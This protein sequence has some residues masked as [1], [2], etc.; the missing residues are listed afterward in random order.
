MK[1][2]GA[3]SFREVPGL[4]V[5]K[6]ERLSKT[7]RGSNMNVRHT[8][9]C[10]FFLSANT[11]I[12]NAAMPII[13]GKEGGNITHEC[14]FILFGRWKALYKE[15]SSLIETFENRA[16][17][18]RYSINY[19]PGRIIS[20]TVLYVSITNLTKSDSGRYRC[21]LGPM[22]LPNSTEEFELRVED[23]INTPTSTQTLTSS[24]GSST[25]SSTQTP[26]ARPA[27]NTGLITEG[28]TVI[29]GK[30]GGNITHECKFYSIASRRAFYKE[31]DILI[32]TQKDK[33][34]RGRY[35]IEY[36]PATLTSSLYVSITNLTKSDAGKY[37]CV[38]KRDYFI[39]ST[40]EFVLRVEDAPNTLKPNW[41]PEPF[42]TSVPSTSTPTTTQ[43]L[44]SSSGSSTPSSTQSL[45]SSSGSSTPSSTQTPA[46]RPGTLLYVRL[47]LVI[48]IFISSAAVLIYCRK[49][50]CKPKGPPQ[51]TEYVNVTE[52]GR[53][54]E[55]IREEDRQSRSPP[56]EI[57]TVYAHAKYTKPNAAEGTD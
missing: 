27:G 14:K 49:T 2:G 19:A 51:E 1:R 28:I 7:T 42:P 15:N 13:T 23:D 26:A 33:A 40:E 38:L 47:T 10:F 43:S 3:Q 5:K 17:C 57:S 45:T 29:T 34:Q 35:S 4:P 56:V 6:E 32:E 9:I 30:E 48:M 54:Y 36:K 37:R 52:A 50:D 46:A 20:K 41:T 39:E 21:V 16:Q 25:P 18:G 31:N 12:I 22:W 8:L 11:G 53:V 55:E 44:T 24:S